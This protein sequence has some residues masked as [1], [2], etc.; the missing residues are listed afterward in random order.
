MEN[1]RVDKAHTSLEILSY[2]THYHCILLED[3]TFL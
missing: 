2:S 1:I 3:A